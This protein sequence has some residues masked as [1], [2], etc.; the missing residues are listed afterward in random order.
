MPKTAISDAEDIHF[1]RRFIAPLFCQSSMGG[2]REGCDS[3]QE[4]RR[5]EDLEKQNAANS[6]NG[7]V[8]SSGAGTPIR[9]SARLSI[10]SINQNS[11]IYSAS[12]SFMTVFRIIRPLLVARIISSFM[13]II[14]RDVRCSNVS[15]DKDLPLSEV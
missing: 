13:S 4:C 2:P 11:L 14:F 10:P 12:I 15:C 8:G 6:R 9:P 3:S 1:I 5:S 7:T